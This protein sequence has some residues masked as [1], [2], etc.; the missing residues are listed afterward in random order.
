MLGS[1]RVRSRMTIAGWRCWLLAALAAGVSAPAAAQRG[2]VLEV[3]AFSRASPGDEVPGWGPYII[4]ASKPRTQY[5]LAAVDGTVALEAVAEQSAS[6]LQRPMR[7][8]ARQFP[9]VEWRWKIAAPVPGADVREGSREDA[10]VRVLLAFH[11]DKDKLGFFE[12]SK[13]RIAKSLSGQDPPYATLMYIWANDIPPETVV[14]NPHTSRVRMIVVESGDARVGEWVSY[15]RDVLADYRRAFEEEPEE[16]LGVGVMTD[17][18]NT[19]ERAR[20]W[21]GDITFRTR[22]PRAP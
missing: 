15:R 9:F 6:G 1:P 18:D 4:S 7:I 11:G 3:A 8:D 13:L 12:R 21:Y 16:L 22:A 10:P 2:D 5:R 17:T 19:G 14:H 20:A